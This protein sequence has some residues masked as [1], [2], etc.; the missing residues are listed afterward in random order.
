MLSIIHVSQW[1]Y[2]SSVWPKASE[3]CLISLLILENTQKYKM[4]Q[5]VNIFHVRFSF[6]LM[7][8]ENDEP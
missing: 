8:S 4:H 5:M 6:V 7:E 2:L 3:F 1:S